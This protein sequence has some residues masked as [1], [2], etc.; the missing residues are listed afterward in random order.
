MCSAVQAVSQVQAGGAS[1]AS[2]TARAVPGSKLII[3]Q[4]ASKMLTILRFIR[5][6][7]LS[8]A[9]APGQGGSPQ[10]LLP[11]MEL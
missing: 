6:S 7:I 1:G 5:S 11:W 4:A 9:V 2:S 8:G 3:M 10:G